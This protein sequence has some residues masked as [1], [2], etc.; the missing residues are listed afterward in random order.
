MTRRMIAV[1]LLSLMT[2]AAALAGRFPHAEFTMPPSDIIFSHANHVDLSCEDCHTDIR[3]STSSDERN[4]P[5]MDVCGMC[6]D[7]EDFDLCGQ[8]H[9]NTEEPEAIPH[10]TRP[11]KF[12]H[13]GH[14]DRGA[15]CSV[16]HDGIATSEE[17]SIKYMPKMSICLACHDGVEAP[18]ACS[19]CH[20]QSPTLADI[21][22]ADWRH[23][24]GDLAS[25]ERD[26]CRQCHAFEYS[27][28]QCH[29]G[30]NLTGNI[31]DLNYKYTHGLDARSKRFDCS[32]CHEERSFCNDCH[33]RENLIPLLHS[34]MTWRSDHGRAAR[35]DVEN[36]AACHDSDDPTCARAG[37]HRDSDG[38]RGTNPR[39]HA[40]SMTLFDSHGPWHNDDGYYCFQC[41]TDTRTRGV[42]FCGYCHR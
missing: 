27:C 3:Q 10:P 30:D 26:W 25:L 29:R 38:I 33:E 2:A 9:R 12:S 13:A 1:T 19:L 31:H 4:F 14:L 16:C 37:C 42:G 34:S 20:G 17:S 24:H 5:T 28:A 41:H 11:V 32:A 36:C 39:Y 21:H 6:H 8:C 7:V 35:R 22:P 18:N 15:E 23:Q 40:A